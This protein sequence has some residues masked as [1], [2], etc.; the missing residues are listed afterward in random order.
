MNSLSIKTD[1]FISICEIV[2]ELH[3]WKIT[4]QRKESWLA[5]CLG[6][7]VDTLNL[8]QVLHCLKLHPDG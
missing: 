3:W 1:E 2:W 7:V 6:S 5:G 4:Q 8:R